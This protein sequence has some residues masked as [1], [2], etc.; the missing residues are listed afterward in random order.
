V[1]RILSRAKA[2]G[3]L[4]RLFFATKSNKKQPTSG[5]IRLSTPFATAKLRLTLSPDQKL[6]VA[7]SPEFR[8][9]VHDFFF[10]KP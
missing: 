3:G 2:L 1:S 10:E 6:P 4:E 7:A 5:R 8:G 9:H